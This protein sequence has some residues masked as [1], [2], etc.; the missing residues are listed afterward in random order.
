MDYTVLLKYPR[1][2]FQAARQCHHQ[3]N[4][5]MAGDQHHELRLPC[6]LAAKDGHNRD[7]ALL[8]DILVG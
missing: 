2:L 1:V 4:A 6:G 5:R 8:T 3:T 7:T